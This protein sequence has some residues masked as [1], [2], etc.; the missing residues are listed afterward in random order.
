M[1]SPRIALVAIPLMARSGVYRS[2]HDLVRAAAELGLEWSAL[3]GM[4]PDAP[5]S[6]IETSGVHEFTFDR[7][8]TSSLRDIAS[9]IDSS[10]EV[11]AADVVITLISQSDIAMAKTER[12]RDTAWIAWVRG[13]PWPGAGEQSNLR[14][15]ALMALETKALRRADEVWATTQVLASEFASA[16]RAII[17]PAGIAAMN[18]VSWGEDGKLPLV[19]AGR[20]DIDKRPG[21]FLDV[22][23]HSGHRG[24]IYG[25]GPLTEELR[26]RNVA[27]V[28]WA[29]WASADSLWNDASIYVGTSA[30]EAFGRSAVEAA[31]AGLPVILASDYGAAPLLFTDPQL[32]Q[33]C[34]V[35][36]SDPSEWASAVQ[37]LIED[38]ELRRT[39][40]DHVNQNAAALTIGASVKRATMQAAALLERRTA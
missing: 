5:G 4:R 39:V 2:A 10:P 9:T 21:L 31:A 20:V 12:R 11:R 27:G 37:T 30:R 15:L 40:S 29:G 6:P 17:V 19:W 25:E 33:L 32:S 23:Q 34:V 36:S 35:G 1:T 14:R 22:V 18:R 3:L 7:H 8:G 24:R 28:E 16:R 26:A 38:D 13:K